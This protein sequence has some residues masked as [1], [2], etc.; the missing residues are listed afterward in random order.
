MVKLTVEPAKKIMGL[1]K[2]KLSNDV[3][4]CPICKPER[5]L[6]F[7]YDHYFC[8]KCHF[9]QLVEISQNMREDDE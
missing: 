1:L 8:R 6:S 4:M 5:P 9:I 2:I 7:A 3:R